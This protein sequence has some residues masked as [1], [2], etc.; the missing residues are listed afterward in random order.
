MERKKQ[1]NP[2]SGKYYTEKDFTIGRTIS[3]VG[4]KF[5]LISADQYTEKYMEDN[6]DVF[7]EASTRSILSKIRE[8]GKSFPSLQEYA[9][10]LLQKLDKNGDKFVDFIEFADGLRQMNIHISNHE[11][12]TLMK[13]FD[14]NGDGKISM[15]EFYNTLSQEF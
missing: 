6:A 5:M 4:F 12:H 13:R 3:L 11:Q 15:E 9:I 8:N 10:Y 2:I 14:T 7:P 1:T